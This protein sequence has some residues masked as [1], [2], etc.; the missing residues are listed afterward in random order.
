MVSRV[1]NQIWPVTEAAVDARLEASVLPA[2][3]G[4]AGSSK[5]PVQARIGAPSA[6]KVRVVAATRR[7][8]VRLCPSSNQT[9]GDKSGDAAVTANPDSS[10]EKANG[11]TEH[12]ES[13]GKDASAPKKVVPKSAGGKAKVKAKAKAKGKPTKK[14]KK[15]KIRVWIS[16]LGGLLSL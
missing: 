16:S 1:C 7:S 5:S 13:F 14:K 6:G 4:S 10:V 3:G 11:T 2:N 15:K 8:I 12:G 9:V